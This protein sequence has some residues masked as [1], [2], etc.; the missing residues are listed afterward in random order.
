MTAEVLWC[1]SMPDF[2][3]I[4]VQAL[5]HIGRMDMPEYVI[6]TMLVAPLSI[7][8]QARAAGERAL[9]MIRPKGWEKFPDL[10][11]GTAVDKLRRARAAAKSGEK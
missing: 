2:H 7:Q 10:E 8:R 9:I 5:P 3:A 1:C 6:K 11:P 4:M